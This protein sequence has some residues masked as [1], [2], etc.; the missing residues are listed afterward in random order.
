MRRTVTVR[1]V[2]A[3][4]K[5]GKRDTSSRGPCSRRQNANIGVPGEVHF[6]TSPPSQLMLSAAGVWLQPKCPTSELYAVSVEPHENVGHQILAPSRAN[7][8][9]R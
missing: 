2:P 4:S 1:S 6:T 3:Q 8:I 9:N 7:G 5:G